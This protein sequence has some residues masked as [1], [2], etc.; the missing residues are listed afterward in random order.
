MKGMTEGAKQPYK[1]TPFMNAPCTL[2]L[3]F[4]GGRG[5]FIH[6]VICEG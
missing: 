3:R 2:G 4:G 6:R 5:E 1:Q